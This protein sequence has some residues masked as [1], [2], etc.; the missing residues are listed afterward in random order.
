MTCKSHCKKKLMTFNFQK[1]KFMVTSNTQNKIFIV[2][3][4]GNL[5]PTCKLDM[6]HVPKFVWRH[7]AF[8]LGI[9]PA[10][11]CCAKMNVQ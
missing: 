11:I 7:F 2:E 10:S 3:F 8:L 4:L 6:S 9:V 1:L 5:G